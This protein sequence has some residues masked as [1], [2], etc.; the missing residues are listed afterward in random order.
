MAIAPIWDERSV[1]CSCNGGNDGKGHGLEA[2]GRC[3]TSSPTLVLVRRRTR[4]L[5]AFGCHEAKRSLVP[6]R[7]ADELLI[8]AYYRYC[9]SSNRTQ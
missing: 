9:P 2:E 3:G 7:H 4:Y 1:E 5:E 8:F 6:L